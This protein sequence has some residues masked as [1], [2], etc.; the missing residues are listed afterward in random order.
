MVVVFVGHREINA[1]EKLKEQIKKVIYE[2]ISVQKKTIF[3]CGGYGK[4]DLLCA[5]VVKKLKK[6]EI[7]I[8]SFFVTPYVGVNY[9]NKLKSIEESNLYDGIVIPPIKNT[10]YKYSICRRN[11]F[12]VDWS[13]MIISYVN[14]NWGGAYKTL[15]YARQ[16]KKRIINLAE[17]DKV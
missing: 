14:H 11:Q 16:K 1:T 9:W 15:E 2:S 6:K 5:Q 3:Y 4:F 8:N 13:D 10:P 17:I 12:M 7:N